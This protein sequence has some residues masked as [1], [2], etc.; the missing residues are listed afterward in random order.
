MNDETRERPI[1]VPSSDTAAGTTGR[2]PDEGVRGLGARGLGE[3]F[4]EAPKFGFIPV[5]S[6]DAARNVFRGVAGRSGFRYW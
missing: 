3:G 2:P 1:A 5:P 4:E 6:P